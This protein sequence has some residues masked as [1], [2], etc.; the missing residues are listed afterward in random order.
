MSD[1]LKKLVELVTD[2][3][4]PKVLTWTGAGEHAS[5]RGVII[6]P[7]GYQIVRDPPRHHGAAKH[8]IGDVYS[9][10]QWLT[11]HAD[12][13][14]VQ[15]LVGSKA[16]TAGVDPRDPA[17]DVVRV[18][19][20]QSPELKAWAQ[21]CSVGAL[22]LADLHRFIRKFKHTIPEASNLLAK[23]A[24]FSSQAK[25]GIKMDIAPNGAI[26]AMSS[27]RS[28]SFGSEL[29]GE[30]PLRLPV[31]TGLRDERGPVEFEGVRIL[32]T[33][34]SNGDPTVRLE[35]LGLEDVLLKAQHKAAE[36]LRHHLRSGPWSVTV[37]DYQVE[38][39]ELLVPLSRV[40]AGDRASDRWGGGGGGGVEAVGGVT[41]NTF[42]DFSCGEAAVDG[43][44]TPPSDPGPGVAPEI[45]DGP[46][47]GGA[48]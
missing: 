4:G 1:I 3:V 39:V 40:Y 38:Q 46:A 7:P 43:L 22:G 15:V 45:G 44:S 25:T 34:S 2:L 14:R 23:V 21:A 19:W 29:P 8:E 35:M 36:F 11:R 18:A 33:P 10:A 17:G 32:L 6:A 13:G 42:G 28:T 16:V 5:G 47:D 30:I 37:G 48:P 9:L 41:Y 24:G 12:P 31:W 27:D 20:Q 26:T